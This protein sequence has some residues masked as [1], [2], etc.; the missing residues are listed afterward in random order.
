MVS[1]EERLKRLE[2][3]VTQDTNIIFVNDRDAEIKG[4]TIC[5]NTGGKLVER[6]PGENLEDLQ[7]RCRDLDKEARR[8][9]INRSKGTVVFAEYEVEP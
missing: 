7:D 3:Y 8:N 9:P 4:Y 6:L 5:H 1:I 2:G